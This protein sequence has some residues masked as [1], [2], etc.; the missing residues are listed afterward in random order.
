M[1]GLELFNNAPL[2]LQD[3]SYLEAKGKPSSGEYVG[4][5]IATNSSI[6]VTDNAEIKSGRNKVLQLTL[7]A[8]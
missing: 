1:S 4:C 2:V 3:N 8:L 5:G 6:R 7:A